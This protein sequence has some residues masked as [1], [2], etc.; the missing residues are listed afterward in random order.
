MYLQVLDIV[1]KN[2]LDVSEKGSARSPFQAPLGIV[3]MQRLLLGEELNEETLT[4]RAARAIAPV[5]VRL[6]SPQAVEEKPDDVRTVVRVNVEQKLSDVRSQLRARSQE[7]T[8]VASGEKQLCSQLGRETAT[9]ST[10]I[11]CVPVVV[12]LRSP[13]AAEAKQDKCCCAVEPKDIIG[14]NIMEVSENG[15]ARSPGGTASAA[16]ALAPVVV[17]EKPDDVRTVVRSRSY[18]M[19]IQEADLPASANVLG[20]ALHNYGMMG[21]VAEVLN[22]DYKPVSV[23]YK[24]WNH[25]QN[26]QRPR[27]AVGVDDI[28]W[29]GD[30]GE[31]G[32]A[33]AVEL[34][35]MVLER[36]ERSVV[37]RR[38]IASLAERMRETFI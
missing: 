29:V 4:V 7:Q 38:A 22:L 20:G 13:Q 14:Q 32:V 30:T 34:P 3:E 19:Y 10:A 26:V 1:G 33:S 5:A 23:M 8:P 27:G 9:V 37:I 21:L 17:E 12:R 35:E 6:R 16:S 31:M 2:I 25:P 15:S 28:E 18:R 24:K 36:D 11:E